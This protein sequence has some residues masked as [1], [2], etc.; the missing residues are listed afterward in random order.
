MD[1]NSKN[2]YI[3]NINNKIEKLDLIK[4]KYNIELIEKNQVLEDN[5]SS[6]KKIRFK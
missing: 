2:Y 6:L 5:I 1:E 4:N 3:E